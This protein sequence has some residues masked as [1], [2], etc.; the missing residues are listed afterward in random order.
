MLCSGWDSTSIATPP[1]LPTL[2]N[3]D[4]GQTH[5]LHALKTSI[6]IA[7][8]GIMKPLR[9][10]A[11]ENTLRKK[12]EADAGDS[13]LICKNP[14]YGHWKIVVEPILGIKRKG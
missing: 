8:D 6:R 2:T 13:R 14:D 10:T 3:P 9:Y 5:L 7:P 4:N 12:L 11:V 1:C